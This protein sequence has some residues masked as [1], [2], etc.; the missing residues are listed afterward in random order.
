[1]RLADQ[2]G[3]Y[4][5][6]RMLGRGAMG[7]VYLAEHGGAPVAIKAVYHGP[8]PEDEQ[9]LEAE[10]TGAELQQKLA[11]VDPRVVG[12]NG[13][14]LIQD[15]LV[16]EMEYIEGE[17]LSTIMARGPLGPGRA[18]VIGVE[19]C[20]MLENL[21]AFATTVGD[22]HFV[23]VVH[24]DL[25]PRNIRVHTSG[26]I[27]VMDFG[28]AKALSYTRKYTHNVFASTA[29]CSPERLET[30]SMDAQ[31]DLWSVGVLLY[32]M[33]AGRLPFD[34][35]TK[36]QLERRIRSF[37]PPDPLPPECPASLCDIIFTML[38]RDPERRIPTAGEAG[39][40]LER[41]INGQPVL[42]R[43][44]EPSSCEND[45]TVR[46]M[47][48]GV[49]DVAVADERTV[50][51]SDPRKAPGAAP[52]VRPALQRLT[53]SHRTL[54]LG[55]LAIF[56]FL[57]VASAVLMAQQVWVWNSAKK[58]KADLE[59]GQISDL[60]KAWERYMQ[61][62]EH[63]HL[64]FLLW[65]VR[66]P[67]KARLM[68]SGD[69]TVRE[70]R[71]A[72]TPTVRESQWRQ[73]R[74]HFSRALQIDPGDKAV[75]GRVRLCEGHLERIN[76]RGTSRMKRLNMAVVRFNQA[77]E[78][79]SKSPDPYLG[80]ARI[81]VYDLNDVDKAEDALEK[82]SKYGHPAGNREKAQLADGYRQRADRTWRE[83][84]RLVS[85][86]DHEKEYLEKAKK[87]YLQAIDL[88]QRIGLWGNSLERR[89]QALQALEAVEKRL[90]ELRKG[91]SLF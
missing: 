81:Y 43:P 48:A 6:L 21:Q 44:P 9:V 72:E 41:F 42:A 11:S 90:Q 84:R 46:T 79:L 36:E 76:A 25:K 87:D 85:T 10:R 80:L 50:R 75:Q 31:S 52:K 3:P 54:R 12:V 65:G 35:R 62:Q 15:Y 82:A 74:D 40:D 14:G 68:A 7:E 57:A 4:R 49:G 24:G 13:F 53:S 38:A 39:G 20:E 5:I 27:K 58:L 1:M 28:I 45:A 51:T 47:A 2:F 66:G 26:R 64:P 78:L 61:I 89:M 55:C 73:A 59:N 56:A 16:I 70:Y 88:Y 37:Q 34:E 30:Q 19:L 71:D 29:Y 33:V 83:S 8:D 69:E 23:G 22:Q 91:G 32:Q 86:P 67:L 63:S 17:D 60:G 18:A 77:A